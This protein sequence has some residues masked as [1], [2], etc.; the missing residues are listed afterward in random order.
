MTRAELQDIV[1]S[2]REYL[3]WLDWQEVR[4]AWAPTAVRVVGEW[5]GEGYDETTWYDAS[6]QQIYPLCPH[7]PRCC[8]K[9]STDC[10]WNNDEYIDAQWNLP[11]IYDDTLT[12]PIAPPDLRILAIIT[13]LEAPCNSANSIQAPASG[14]CTVSVSE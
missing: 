7:E 10:K 3:A 12:F 1:D 6:G 13:L 9:M 11:R 8:E 5:N 4:D 2:L 14:G